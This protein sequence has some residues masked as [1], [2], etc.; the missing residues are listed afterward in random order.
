VSGL[1]ELH[2]K[3][4]GTTP[5]GGSPRFNSGV[6][7]ELTTSG[8]ERVIHQFKASDRAQIPF[9][10]AVLGDKLYGTTLQGGKGLGV[11]FEVTPRGEYRNLYEFGNRDSGNATALIAFHG[12]LLGTTGGMLDKHGDW[13]NGTVFEF[14]P[15]HQYRILTRVGGPHVGGPQGAVTPLNGRLYG[16][17]STGFKDGSGGVFEVNASGRERSIAFFQNK[18]DGTNP[19]PLVARNGRLYGAM[20]WGGRLSDG[21]GAIFE[22]TPPHE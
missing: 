20:R 11:I 18:P 6:I 2:G 13:R 5:Y 22:V 12:T 15:P 4:Y 16:I 17:S 21:G 8:A 7:F 3:L 19:S 1:V 10:L 14:R 9:G